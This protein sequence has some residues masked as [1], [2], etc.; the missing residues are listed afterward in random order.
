MMKTRVKAPNNHYWVKLGE[1]SYK[2]VEHNNVFKAKK[3]I[4]Q[5]A[6]FDTEKK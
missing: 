3:G 4:S 2:L 6:L 5:Y 1:N